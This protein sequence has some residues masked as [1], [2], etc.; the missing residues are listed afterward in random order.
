M[1]LTA[2]R[3]VSPK[4]QEGINAF[5]YLH[6]PYHWLGEPPPEIMNDPGH[7]TNSHVEVPPP[8]NRVRSYLDIIAPDH[9]PSDKIARDVVDAVSLLSARP[10]PIKIHSG[11]TTFIF[12]AELRLAEGWQGELKALLWRALAVRA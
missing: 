10:L 3:V 9:V 6:G 1:R 12:N 7:R 11:D 8:G 5:C 2:Q 4:G